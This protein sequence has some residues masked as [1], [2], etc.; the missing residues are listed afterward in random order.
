M[1]SPAGSP[2][3]PETL[4][5]IITGISTSSAD[6]VLDTPAVNDLKTCA[7]A[8]YKHYHSLGNRIF[9]ADARRK[10]SIVKDLFDACQQGMAIK[11]AQDALTTFMKSVTNDCCNSTEKG[12]LHDLVQ[13]IGTKGTEEQQALFGEA[14]AL[15]QAKKNEHGSV[16]SSPTSHGTAATHYEAAYDES[17]KSEPKKHYLE[18]ALYH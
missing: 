5:E 3:P 17:K 7:N 9:S 16:F 15:R 6:A 14:N 2:P 12:K 4:Q 10:A 11:N 13:A 1:A 8:L 18:N